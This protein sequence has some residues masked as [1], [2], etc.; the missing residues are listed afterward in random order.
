MPG[1]DRT[2]P[3]GLGPMT[4]RAAGY[5]AGYGVPGYMN[6][7]PGRGGRGGRGMGRGGYGYGRGGWRSRFW[8]TGPPVWSHFGAAPWGAWGAPPV[9]AGP[10]TSQQEVDLLKQQAQFFEQSLGDIRK[11]ID[12]L[13]AGVVEEE[14]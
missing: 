8:A 10:A 12:E 2:G 1:G 6:F 11:R 4:G 7:G 13:E 9:V 5:C 3:M 14:K